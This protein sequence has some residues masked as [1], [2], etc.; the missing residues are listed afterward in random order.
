MTLKKSLELKSGH[1]TRIS[2]LVGILGGIGLILA[3]VGLYGI[4]AYVSNQRTRE[5]GIRM[6][7]GAQ[8]NQVM[9]LVLKQGMVLIL[10]WRRFG[11]AGQLSLHPSD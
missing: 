6:A 11:C 9:W 7:L 10:S 5:I 2:L 3:V 4:L 1:R 8:I